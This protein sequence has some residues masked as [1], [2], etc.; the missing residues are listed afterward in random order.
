MML[1]FPAEQA[2]RSADS[3]LKPN[4]GA[5]QVRMQASL[6]VYRFWL[7]YL[8]RLVGS[9]SVVAAPNSTV[10]FVLSLS[11]HFSP[12]HVG[13]TQLHRLPWIPLTISSPC[14]RGP[15]RSITTSSWSWRRGNMQLQSHRP[16]SQAFGECFWQ[17]TNQWLCSIMCPTNFGP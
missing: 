6:S 7:E 11:D 5:M 3:P 13:A 1:R 4:S 8:A 2:I 12:N 16:D 17:A 15:L 10:G 9:Q 14:I